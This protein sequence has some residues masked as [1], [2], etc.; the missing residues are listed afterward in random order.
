MEDDE[1]QTGSGNPETA[2]DGEAVSGFPEPP[3]SDDEDRE[4]DAEPH[5]SLSNPVGDPD[6]TEWPDPYETREDPRG[7]DAHPNAGDRSSS[8]P[9]PSKDPEAGQWEAPERDNLD[10]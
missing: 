10:D 7:P 6:P 2:P 3:L 5:H 4:R 1:R 9:H 8:E